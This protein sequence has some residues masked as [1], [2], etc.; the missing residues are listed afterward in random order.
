[1]V[2]AGGTRSPQARPA[3]GGAVSVINKML[4]E[5]DRRQAVPAPGGPALRPMR[6]RAVAG[7]DDKVAFW[8]VLAFLMLASA[9][10]VAVLVYQ[11]DMPPLVTNLAYKARGD[12]LLRSVP[13]P[14]PAVATAVEPSTAIASTAPELFK[15]APSI[16][17]PI[18][19]ER[20]RQLAGTQAPAP[21]RKPAPQPIAAAKSAEPSR[22][23]I[24]PADSARPPGRVERLERPRT[25]QDQAEADFRRAVALLNQGRPGDAQEALSAAIR[26]DRNHEAARQALAAL[27]LEQHNLGAAR[28]LLQDGLAINP[29]NALFASALARILIESKE[30]EKA[31]EVL[32]GA[33]PSGASSADFQALAGAIQQRLGRHRDAMEAYRTALRLSPGSGASWMGLGISLEALEHRPEAAEAFRRAIATGSLSAELRGL[34][35]NRLRRIQ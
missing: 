5:L 14:P 22:A 20:A 15:L 11:L 23:A 9:A 21:A 33:G 19:A 25:P 2:V 13:P 1:M 31:L 7:S 17:T 30:Y 18:P 26:A 8:R 6:G 12:A 3:L 4:Q 27:L 24:A 34:A 29:G 28:A 35:E 10:W 32:Q 16:D